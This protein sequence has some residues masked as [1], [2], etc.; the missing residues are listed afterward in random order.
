M[1]MKIIN[2]IK[3]I[4]NRLMDITGMLFDRIISSV[5][6]FIAM[7]GRLFKRIVSKINRK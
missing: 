6:H 5:A 1:I 4:L 7:P 3:K 2:E